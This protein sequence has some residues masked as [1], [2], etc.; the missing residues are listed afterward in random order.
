MDEILALLGDKY[1]TQNQFETFHMMIQSFHIFESYYRQK[2]YAFSHSIGCFLK[3]QHFKE[4]LD[5]AITLDDHCF[6]LE[7]DKHWLTIQT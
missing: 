4:K 6:I 3:V 5:D 2:N 7:I 1:R